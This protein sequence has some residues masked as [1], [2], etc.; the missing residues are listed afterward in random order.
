MY[1][2]E[3][4]M[5]LTRNPG[6]VAGLWYLLI[7]L[8]G[9]LR[10]MYIPSKLFVTGNAAATV[11]NI[12]AHQSLFRSGIVS[13]MAGAL[14]LVLVTLAFYRMFAGVDRNLAVLVVIFGGVM[15]AVISFIGI[16]SDFGVLMVVRG[17]DFLSV[18]DKAQRDA[19]AMLFL[20]LGDYQ[21][22]AAE[23]L[24]GVWLLPLAALVYRSRF[25]PRLIGV[26]LA[27]NGFAYVIISLTGTLLPQYQAKVFNLSFPA[28]LGEIVL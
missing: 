2:K 6:R 12:S 18:F 16:V 3:G 8:L 13:S 15:P 11:N 9:P 4:N 10:L 5:S 14:I 23:I 20:N 28:L 24:W 19:L 1:S 17:T 25:L 27:I 26:W 7:V 21:N 22:T